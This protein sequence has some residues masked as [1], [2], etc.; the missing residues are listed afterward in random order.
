MADE[1]ISR[2]A[3]LTALQDSD[4]FN[5]TERQLRAIRELSAAD[6]A[7]VRHGRWEWDTEDIYRCSNC[8]EKSHVKEVMGHPEWDYCPNCG[9]K[10]DGGKDD[11]AD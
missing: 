2:E 5:T 7:Q 4:L 8:A 10:M 3:A 1:Y 6:V 9:A 11:E